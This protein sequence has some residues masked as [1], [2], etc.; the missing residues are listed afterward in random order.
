MSSQNGFLFAVQN[1]HST[2]QQ[3][4]QTNSLASSD[5]SQTAISLEP[6]I[7]DSQWRHQR[8][9]TEMPLDAIG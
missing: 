5:E 8:T 7:L 3:R 4:Y 9:Q 6:L 1:V 2:S